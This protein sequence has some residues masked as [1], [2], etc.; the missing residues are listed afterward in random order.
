ME[1]QAHT[2][3]QVVRTGS[4][5]LLGTQYP[6]AVS[7]C[8]TKIASKTVAEVSTLPPMALLFAAKPTKA[9]FHCI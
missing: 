2:N 6:S 5:Q 7:Q 1:E 4:S 3:W 8:L 9:P